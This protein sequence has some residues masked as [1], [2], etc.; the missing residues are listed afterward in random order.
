[1][2]YAFRTLCFLF[3]NF[4]VFRNSGTETVSHNTI[5]CPVTNTKE[6]QYHMQQ[7]WPTGFP[8]I[9][10]VDPYMLS[11]PVQLKRQCWTE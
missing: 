7:N 4:H 8:Y 9:N 6:C 5:F 2:A 3:C 11:I 1:L 10:F